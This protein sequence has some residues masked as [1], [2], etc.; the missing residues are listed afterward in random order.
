MKRKLGSI[1]VD[2]TQSNTPAEMAKTRPR[3]K[4][5]IPTPRL[6]RKCPKRNNIKTE[7]PLPELSKILQIMAPAHLD[8]L[9]AIWDDDKRLPT[10]QSRRAW[11]LARNLKPEIVHRWWY[12][13][14]QIAAKTGTKLPKD[15]YELPVGT[16]PVIIKLATPKEDSEEETTVQDIQETSSTVIDLSS[17]PSSS[18]SA[19]CYDSAESNPDALT[20][21]ALVA[22]SST[23]ERTLE[24][25]GAYNQHTLCDFSSSSSSSRSTPSSMVLSS[26]PAPYF[27]CSP[28]P[29]YVLTLP[30]PATER[31]DS[32]VLTNWCSGSLND[33]SDYTCSLCQISPETGIVNQFLRPACLTS[34]FCGFDSYIS[35]CFLG[36][37]RYQRI[38]ESHIQHRLIAHSTG[39][40]S[41]R[42]TLTSSP[43]RLDSTHATFCYSVSLSLSWYDSDY[44]E[45]DS[46]SNSFRSLWLLLLCFS[47]VSWRK[48][49]CVWWLSCRPMYAGYSTN[50][51]DGKVV[52]D[53]ASTE[54]L[55]DIALLQ[56]IT[57]LLFFSFADWY[58]AKVNW[59][60]VLCIPRI[61]WLESRG[62]E[63]ESDHKAYIHH[64]KRYNGE[65]LERFPR[66]VALLSPS[67]PSS[68]FTWI[69]FMQA[70]R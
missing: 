1:A 25:K 60:F 15:T 51:G 10:P 6:A 37:N 56:S 24:E 35:I 36:G 52:V 33:H 59:S 31:Q 46:S 41:R 55:S 48:Q 42:S 12:R 53:L 8:E 19:T 38:S 32:S 50:W 66:R 63:V 9:S 2:S 64:H 54:F 13:R 20:M 70:L 61:S 11:A 27:P 65:W 57:S 14:K 68:N 18:S 16:P 40:R 7:E 23:M 22:S 45:F 17:C 21:L 26:S 69:V 43:D 34:C 4:P 44:H 28:L 39:T 62:R 58:L 47:I 49:L 67:S 5:F 29:E 3:N 30:P